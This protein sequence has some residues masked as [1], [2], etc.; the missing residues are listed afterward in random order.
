[1]HCQGHEHFYPKTSVPYAKYVPIEKESELD[2]FVEEAVGFINLY[3]TKTN[4]SMP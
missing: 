1:M 3:L 2:D 4:V